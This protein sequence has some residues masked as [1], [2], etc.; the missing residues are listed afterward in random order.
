MRNPALAIIGLV[1]AALIGSLLYHDVLNRKAEQRALVVLRDESQAT[2]QVLESLVADQKRIHETV[3]QT[4]EAIEAA[5]DESASVIRDDVMRTAAMRGSIVEYYYSTLK[6]PASNE[7]ARVPPPDRYRGRSLRSASVSSGGIIDLVFDG[8]SGIE[9]GRIRF[10][11]DVS[12]ANSMGIDWHCETHDYALIKRALPD[13]TYL[14][15][16]SGSAPIATPAM[17]SRPSTRH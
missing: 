12:H 5:K 6:M 11:P 9:G 3:T 4:H 8:K 13:C 1:V 15:H 17:N 7:E 2:R 14:P 16:E 10:V